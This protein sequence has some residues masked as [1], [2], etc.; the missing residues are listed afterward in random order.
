MNVMIL[1]SRSIGK[2]RH[3]NLS[4]PVTLSL[5]TLA[6]LG[7]LVSSFA[8]GLQIG[9]R[10]VTRMALLN[11]G[12]AV[13]AQQAEVAALKSQLQDRVD[14]LAMRLGVMNAH[15]GA[16]GLQGVSY[17]QRGRVSHIVSARLEGSSQHSH[18]AVGQLSAYQFAGQ[19]N[20]ARAPQ[21]VDAIDLVEKSEGIADA[22]R[23]TLREQRMQVFRQAAATETETGRHAAMT[24]PAVET[25]SIG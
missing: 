22:Q 4:H 7:I 13:R 9:E 17:R 10:S 5:V 16:I 15:L 20:D 21:S 11:P 25:K 12:A 14:A 6:A 8:L 19:L 3:F 2:A 23:G 24:D 18:V 1:F